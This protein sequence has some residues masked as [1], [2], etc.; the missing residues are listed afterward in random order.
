MGGAGGTDADAIHDNVAAEISAIA[1]KATPTTSDYL[2]IEDAADSDNKKSITIGDLPAA[3]PASHALGGSEHSSSTLAQ[4][5]ALVSDATLDDSSDPRTDTTAIHTDGSAEISGLTEK[6]SPVGADLLVIEDSAAANVKKRV[7]ITNLPGGADADAIHDNAAGEIAAVTEKTVPVAADLLLI[8]DSADSNNKKRVQVGNLPS[9]ATSLQGDDIDASIAPAD[10]QVLTWD[11]GSTHWTASS[12]DEGT[13]YMELGENHTL[14][15]AG[16]SPDTETFGGGIFD[17]GLHNAVTFRAAISST[18]ASTGTS[19]VKLYDD[20]STSTPGTP[21]LVATL[22]Q[23]SDASTYEVFEQAL[24]IVASS[25]STNEILS[26]ARV[27]R[28]VVENTATSGDTTEVRTAGFIATGNADVVIV[29]ADYVQAI[30]MSLN[31]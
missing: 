28:V 13:A 21:R 9:D 26:E 31:A 25:A 8:E 12:P 14:T 2:V 18:F 20:G 29:A 10:G 11:N 19:E 5:N 3:T 22:S 4:V 15:S 23:T 30:A 16:G 17:A 24:T 7:Q 6:A 1:A 27:Y